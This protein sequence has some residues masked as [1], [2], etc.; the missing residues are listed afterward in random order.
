MVIR[1]LSD[2]SVLVT[3]TG[4]RNGE[5]NTVGGFSVA[6][7]TRSVVLLDTSSPCFSMDSTEYPHY[8]SQARRDAFMCMKQVT[9]GSAMVAVNSFGLFSDWFLPLWAQY[10]SSAVSGPLP[11]DDPTPSVLA[12]DFQPITLG[13][14]VFSLGD[15]RGRSTLKAITTDMWAGI[16]ACEALHWH[17]T[18]EAPTSH[19]LEVTSEVA[20]SSGRLAFV[21][22]Q[23]D[24]YHCVIRTDPFSGA[25]PVVQ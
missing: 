25:V 24:H 15:S 2:G 7:F 4:V 16:E 21:A 23:F 14:G 13:D 18:V 12:F 3:D 5:G 6:Y 19:S 11:P 8:C 9:R 1:Q 17:L 20:R 22:S 10:K